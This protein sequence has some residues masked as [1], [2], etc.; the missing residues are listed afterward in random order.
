MIEYK[1]NILHKGSRAAEL[2]EEKKFKELDLHLRESARTYVPLDPKWQ[3][4]R[5]GDQPFKLM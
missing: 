5:V 2:L 1:G 3:N 4:Y